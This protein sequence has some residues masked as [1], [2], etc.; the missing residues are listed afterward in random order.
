MPLSDEGVAA[1]RADLEKRVLRERGTAL[2]ADLERVQREKETEQREKET[3]KREKEATQAELDKVQREKEASDAENREYGMKFRRERSLGTSF[4]ERGGGGSDD[5][6][7][8]AAS[9][10]GPMWIRGVSTGGGLGQSLPYVAR[11]TVPKFPMECPPYVYIA[12]ERRFD[13]FI[14]N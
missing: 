1:L 8:T 14:T 9:S 2:R 4:G 7:G 13:V 12:W 10:T 11:G 3:M 5:R 6:R